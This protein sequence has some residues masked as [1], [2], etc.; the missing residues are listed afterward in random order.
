MVAEPFVQVRAGANRQKKFAAVS[1]IEA[2][3]TGK[4]LVPGREIA[5]AT[6]LT[7]SQVFSAV[8]AHFTV[9]IEFK[10]EVSILRKY[11]RDLN[12]IRLMFDSG[13]FLISAEISRALILRPFCFQPQKV[14]R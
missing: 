10:P 14:G 12:N 4:G 2:F 11:E 8:K 1:R 3:V 5:K 9:K 6:G 7:P 13:G